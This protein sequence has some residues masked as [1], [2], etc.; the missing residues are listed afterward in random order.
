MPKLWLALALTL[1]GTVHFTDT[2]GDTV[3]PGVTV[4]V[5]DAAGQKTDVVTDE[6]GRYRVP[7]LSR[8]KA[9]VVA[10]L[11]GL[12]QSKHAVCVESEVTVDD[13]QLHMIPSY[14]CLIG[15]SDVPEPAGFELA[16]TVI[17][18]EGRPVGN[19]LIEVRRES[20]TYSSTRADAGGEFVVPVSENGIFDLH[21]RAPGYQDESMPIYEGTPKITVRLHRACGSK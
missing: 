21:V 16:G 8:G 2:T 19:V 6:N 18:A 1:Q 4:T 3:L 20:A 15:G 11:S 7:N 5:V 9:L 13:V 12:G 10:E 14:G 17:D